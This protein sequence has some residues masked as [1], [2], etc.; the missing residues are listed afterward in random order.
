MHLCSLIHFRKDSDEA[1]QDLQNSKN[2]DEKQIIAGESAASEAAMNADGT[3]KATDQVSTAAQ[4]ISAA[5]QAAQSR[6]D[7]ATALAALSGAANPTGGAK[8]L[9]M[10]VNAAN[11]A[12]IQRLLIS[13]MS[14]GPR[15]FDVGIYNC[16]VVE[17]SIEMTGHIW[18]T[19][20]PSEPFS[21]AL[22]LKK[23]LK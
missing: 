10:A 7:T 22:K 4:I 17:Y 23:L 11:N 19:S 2:P 5:A 16:S 6:K 18:F 3:S 14:N 20:F 13:M 8:K 21:N 15:D 9:E 1:V 12:R